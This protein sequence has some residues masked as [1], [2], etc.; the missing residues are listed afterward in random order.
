M[1]R[2]KHLF[3]VVL[4]ALMLHLLI[5]EMRLSIMCTSFP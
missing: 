1:S 3:I 4:V 2:V 5:R